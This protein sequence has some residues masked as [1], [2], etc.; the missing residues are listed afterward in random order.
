M[1]ATL[2]LCAGEH[3]HAQTGRDDTADHVASRKLI[4]ASVVCLC[5]I[6][7]EATGQYAYIFVTV[8]LSVA[9]QELDSE[10]SL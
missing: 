9:I 6:I 2:Y 4:I 3:C 7:G 1:C 8:S 10:A 5:F